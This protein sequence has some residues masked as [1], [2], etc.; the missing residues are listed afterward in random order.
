[1]GESAHAQIPDDRD[2]LPAKE[3]PRPFSAQG[4]ERVPRQQSDRA[5]PVHSLQATDAYNQALALIKDGN[6]AEAERQLRRAIA[7]RP[8]H[9]QAL[10]NLGLLSLSRED[11]DEAI[12]LFGQAI[13]ARP[14]Y[15]RPYNNLGVTYLRK[16]KTDW[17]I[18]QFR[19]A[20]LVDPEYDA[21]RRNLAAAVGRQQP[22]G[23]SL[24]EIPDW[25]PGI[26]RKLF[27]NHA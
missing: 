22:H 12:S 4:A 25:V 1:M 27:K 3:L 6:K 23:E 24:R 9:A 14:K 26:V 17:A 8:D 20:L 21:A 13:R 5:E 19:R 7:I 16:G 2:L 18:A 15:A 11:F 10:N